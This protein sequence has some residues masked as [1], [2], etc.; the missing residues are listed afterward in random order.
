[1]TAN[2]VIGFKIHQHILITA[3][4]L[5]LFSMPAAFTELQTAFLVILEK[6]RIKFNVTQYTACALN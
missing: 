3:M 4:D 5:Y 2:I 1:M 6:Y